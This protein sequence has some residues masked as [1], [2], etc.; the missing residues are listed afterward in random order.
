[1][2]LKLI[3]LDLDDTLWPVEP[4]LKHAEDCF[5]RFLSNQQP[6]IFDCISADDL[7]HHR[8]EMFEQDPRFKHNVSLWRRESLKLF[9]SEHKLSASR[10]DELA[11][12][13]FAVFLEARQQV[14]LFEGAET[15]L[16]ELASRYTLIAL[17]NGN[18]DIRQM[19]VGRYFNAAIR[20]E[21]IGVSKPAPDMFEKALEI[22]RCKAEES[23]HI[24]DDPYYDIAPA[25]ALGMHTL[26]AA[27]TLK[28]P[29]NETSFSHWQEL[30]AR[31]AAISIPL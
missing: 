4:A 30:P 10:A 20:A 1:M 26:R 22:A 27:I 25:Q 17:T 31:I 14:E 2:T 12:Q 9:L 15:V 5:Y 6:A 8:I 18:A 13:A 11:E 21:D 28:F 23:L 3:T 19:P 7:R 24:G 16:A 29:Q